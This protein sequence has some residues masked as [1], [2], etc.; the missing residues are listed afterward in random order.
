[1]K[2]K[3]SQD[4]VLP[5]TSY[6]K[7]LI[8]I[9]ALLQ[10]TVVLDFMILSPLGDILMKSL[11][12]SPSQFGLVVSSY[13]FSAGASGILAAG[14][15]DKFDRK[16]LLLFFYIGFIGGTLC[17]AL[18]NTYYLLL[19][20]RIVTGLFGG[21]IGAVI[22]AIITDVFDIRQRG[23]VMGFVQM[24][25]AV[26]QVLGLPIGLYVANLW[27]WHATFM[28][29]VIVGALI[30]VVMAWRMRPI[31]AHLALQSDKTAF[32]HLQ[33]TFV[34]RHYQIG[35]LAT[36]LLSVGGFML[37]PFGSAYLVNNIKISQHDLPLVFLFSGMTTM[38]IMPL[39]GRL[40][41][42]VNKFKLF[43]VGSVIAIVMIVVYCNMPPIPL[44]QMV[45][46]NMLLFVGI[47]SRILPA[48]TLV[49]GIPEMK[50]RGAFM[51][52]NASL[53]QMAGGIAA[54][55]AGFIVTQ[56]SKTSPLEHY[57]IL[58]W[59]VSF[60]VVVCIFLIYYVSKMVAR[61]ERDNVTAPVAEP[62]HA[63]IVQHEA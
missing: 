37:M 20:A 27:D 22:M 33:H 17:C 10:F 6:Q 53:Q 40:S 34:K 32:R 58:G 35:F 60:F 42:K 15:A 51:S 13:A 28:M 44:W 3:T 54:V 59:V 46:V 18:A 12:I 63:E 11:D 16:K 7:L 21:V 2:T 5:F 47:S 30:G 19:A 9:L 62:V 45:V 55:S 29:I 41:D 48:T 8:A 36:A 24:A 39:V 4:T 56:Q 14:F 52:I 49:T 57:D 43:L 1:M 23:R 61:R 31:D 38:V 50:D 26:S 25:F